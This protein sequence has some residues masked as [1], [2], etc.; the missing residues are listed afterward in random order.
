[1]I[2]EPRVIAVSADDLIAMRAEIVETHGAVFAEPP[3]SEGPAEITAFDA[4]LDRLVRKPGFRACT[5]RDPNGALAGFA[6]GWEGGP[7]DRWW[8]TATS[9]VDAHVR[10]RWFGDCFELVELAVLR[11]SRRRG[12]GGALHDGLLEQTE[13]PHAVLSTHAQAAPARAFYAAREWRVV[14][15]PL[16][17]PGHE[18]P[19]AIMARDLPTRSR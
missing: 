14:L 17:F 19:F 9:A 16:R 5:A 13:R 18:A 2:V 8:D 11:G 10:R 12:V 7:G 3:T 6:F 1:M 4:S 15:E